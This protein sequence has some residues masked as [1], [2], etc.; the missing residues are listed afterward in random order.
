MACFHPIDAW[1]IPGHEFSNGRTIRFGTPPASFLSVAKVFKIPCGT[2]LGCRIDRSKQW[3]LRCVLEAKSHESNCFITLTYNNDN[4]P[5]GGSL[6]FDD[7]TKFFKRFRKKFGYERIRYYAVG[8]YGIKLSRPHFHSIIFGF[9]FPDKELWSFDR[10]CK[11]YR[12]P[13]LEQLW[14]FGFSTV[15]AV[16]FESCAYV[17][18]YVQKKLYRASKDEIE[19]HYGGKIPEM[20]RMSRRPG[21][22]NQFFNDFSSDIYPKDFITYKG[23]KYKPGQ[24]FDMLYRK[25]HP[26]EMLQIKVERMVRAL[27]KIDDSTPDR[28]AVREQVLQLRSKKLIRGFEDVQAESVCNL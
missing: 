24:Y 2:C 3:A 4:L 6:D 13:A 22:A 14:P 10:G 21:I 25:K 9:D 18:R 7:L 23:V 27:E 16:S 20:A 8:E 5:P 15:G 1:S 11:L 26:K 28:L 19:E 12:S 17:A